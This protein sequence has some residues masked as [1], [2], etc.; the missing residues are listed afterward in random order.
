MFTCETNFIKKF[1]L[2][3]KKLSFNQ[4]TKR[5]QETWL[6]HDLL[7]CYFQYRLL[8]ILHNSHWGRFDTTEIHS[9]YP[10]PCITGIRQ[11]VVYLWITPHTLNVLFQT[12]LITH[13]RQQ[14]VKYIILGVKIKRHYLQTVCRLVLN[15]TENWRVV[16]MV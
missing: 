7:H 13:K 4:S 8:S 10:N 3:K 15:H 14:N 12:T 11:K 2:L 6:R 9:V 5:L 1:F 16:H